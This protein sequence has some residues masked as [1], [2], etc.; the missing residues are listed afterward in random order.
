MSVGIGSMRVSRQA[1]A[2]G[3][4]TLF[5]YDQRGWGERSLPSVSRHTVFGVDKVGKT[6][7]GGVQRGLQAI[8][9]RIYDVRFRK[10]EIQSLRVFQKSYEQ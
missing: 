8:L 2:Y 6:I 5:L 10:L 7:G 4:P 3:A 1:E 9:E